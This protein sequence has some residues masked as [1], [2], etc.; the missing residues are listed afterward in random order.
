MQRSK[1]TSPRKEIK[2]NIVNLIRSSVKSERSGTVPRP[3]RGSKI[4]VCL[5]ILMAAMTFLGNRASRADWI[6]HKKCHATWKCDGDSLTGSCEA[7]G[8][9]CEDKGCAD[10]YHE[11]YVEIFNTC[12]WQSTAECVSEP[13]A[14]CLLRDESYIA[15]NCDGYC[16]WVF[17]NDC[18]C[19]CRDSEQY[20]EGGDLHTCSSRC[21]LSQ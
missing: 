6:E 13:N 5:L 11:G 10:V 19:S 12:G 14:D 8:A 18:R 9:V 1:N 17:Y 16:R 4:I 3:Y 7:H 2:M 21:R 20:V 15:T